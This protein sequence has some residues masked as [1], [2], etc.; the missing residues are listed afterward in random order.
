[1]LELTKEQERLFDEGLKKRAEIRKNR[2]ED[3]KKSKARHKR[4]SGLI[5]DEYQSGIMKDESLLPRILMPLTPAQD[6]NVGQILNRLYEEWS[7]T[8][9]ELIYGGVGRKKQKVRQAFLQESD[10]TNDQKMSIFLGAHA[11][12]DHNY[13]RD[14]SL[15]IVTYSLFGMM[16]RNAAQVNGE[17]ES[18]FDSEDF[19]NN[20]AAEIY[21]AFEEWDIRTGNKYTT[22]LEPYIQ[23][24]NRKSRK[25]KDI[26]SDR[27]GHAAIPAYITEFD[28]EIIARGGNP[29]DYSSAEVA[30]WISKT[31]NTSVSAKLVEAYAS[32]QYVSFS[33][34]WDESDDSSESVV[35]AM[36]SLSR[37]SYQSYMFGNP[38]VVVENAT[39]LDEFWE[40]IANQFDPASRQMLIC[41]M[42]AADTVDSESSGLLDL[43][44]AQL[45][46]NKKNTKELAINQYLSLETRASRKKVEKLYDDVLRR[47]RPAFNKERQLIRQKLVSEYEDSMPDEIDIYNLQLEAEQLAFSALDFED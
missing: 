21:D 29:A 9:S 10:L 17:Y 24:A 22:F 23:S 2:L 5:T 15:T 35:E 30:R 37:N 13:M 3:V 18:I 6:N 4:E 45:N 1:M 27:L 43:S 19:F 42:L 20:Q 11:A 14:Q 32:R 16:Y 46:A 12:N 25:S 28:E 31:K 36:A 44:G 33:A 34:V 40:E 8:Y 41:M 39:H 26:T 38:E 7:S 47:I